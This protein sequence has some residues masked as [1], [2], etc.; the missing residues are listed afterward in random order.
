M[1]GLPLDTYL[2]CLFRALASSWTGVRLL[3]DASMTHLTFNPKISAYEKN[4]GLSDEK[5]RENRRRDYEYALK[6]R[7]AALA[8]VPLVEGGR[9]CG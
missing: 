2:A 4:Y 7:H 9:W 3:V 1:A 8:P 5:K 6:V